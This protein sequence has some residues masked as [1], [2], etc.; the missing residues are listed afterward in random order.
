M[1]KGRS[2]R[3]PW[4]PLGRPLT[5]SERARVANAARSLLGWQEH[6]RT[7]PRL[8][9]LPDATP[10]VSL[11]ASGRLVGCFGSTEGDPGE[12]LGRAFTHALADPRYGGVHPQERQSLAMSVSYLRQPARRE[13]DGIERTLEL[14]T[15]GLAAVASVEAAALLLPAVAVDERFDA[16]TLVRVLAEKLAL[17]GGEL[18]RAAVFT[19]ETDTVVARRNERTARLD[20][21]PVDIAARWL[22]A[23]VDSAGCVR[24]G[25]DARAR[26]VH[27]HGDFMHGRAAVVIQALAAHGAYPAKVAR[28]RRWLLA[29]IRAALRGHRRSTWPADRAAAAGAV[30]LAVLAGVA[31]EKELVELAG[32][33]SLAQNPWHAAQVVAALGTLAPRSLFQACIANLDDEPWAPW[34]AIAANVLG[35]AA[36]ARRVE[37]VLAASIRAEPPYRGAAQ[38]TP[39]PEVALT[40]VAVEALAR[41]RR[42]PARTACKRAASFLASLQLLSE[43]IPAPLDPEMAKGAFPLSPIADDLRS[44]VTAHAL[45]ALLSQGPRAR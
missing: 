36:V 1:P 44:D 23:Q 40:A 12:R 42:S 17:S 13:L 45:L 15:H 16:Q 25:V 26:V 3:L 39:I 35:D 32:A 22:A 29:E 37:D 6:L 30:A 27:D 18:A 41:S 34:T 4:K 21:D 24:F 2:G 38:V 10:F 19:F 7:W 14:G 8:V 5:A 11:Y 31:L 9:R 33:E 20:E 43:R 28:A